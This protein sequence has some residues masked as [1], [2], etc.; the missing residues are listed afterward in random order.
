RRPQR[1]FRHTKTR[2]LVRARTLLPGQTEDGE[3]GT[4]R[5]GRIA[6]VLHDGGGASKQPKLDVSGVHEGHHRVHIVSLAVPESL[7]RGRD[8]QQ[9]LET[10]FAEGERRER[11]VPD[12]RN[13]PEGDC[14]EASVAGPE[15]ARQILE[16]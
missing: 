7:A 13:G 14:A 11:V 9:V 16:V 12:L 8:V 2:C 15:G 10:P 6:P 5:G 4:R 3:D 1:P